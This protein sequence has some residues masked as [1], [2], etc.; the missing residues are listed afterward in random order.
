MPT[1]AGRGHVRDPWSLHVAAQSA[2]PGTPPPRGYTRQGL[3]IRPR[4]IACP[5]HA[6]AVLAAAAK[7]PRV[8]P[9][10]GDRR[11]PI[12]DA[13]YDQPADEQLRQRYAWQSRDH[14]ARTVV[15]IAFHVHRAVMARHRIC[16]DTLRRWAQAKSLY[17]QGGDPARVIVSPRTLA[18]LMLCS[19]ETVKRYNR[20]AREA[21]LEYVVEAGRML[22]WRERQAARACGSTQRGLATVAALCTP[23]EV[24]DR[25][26]EA[27]NRTVGRNTPPRGLVSPQSFSRSPAFTNTAATA[28]RTSLRSAQHPRDGGPPL[29][30]TPPTAH[31]PP[32][33]PETPH[34]TPK[35]TA[36]AVQVASTAPRPT[37]RRPRKRRN[38][39]GLGIAI[40][41]VELVPWLRGCPRG[42]IAPMLNKYARADYNWTA[43]RILRAMDAVN[44]RLGYNSP[45]TA[46]TKPWALLAWYLTQIDP[47]ADAP[48]A[49]RLVD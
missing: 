15:S 42:R 10:Q 43:T 7:D 36:K 37:Q 47:V 29:H 27:V 28:N 48:D 39:P 2:L 49:G 40:E 3:R 45:T 31:R 6:T 41:L 8:L 30:G 46:K 14:W 4:M 16:P 12:R 26:I 20:A 44:T 32:Q 5:A 1:I 25:A 24:V 22:T 13:H 17:A 33:P 9:R 21:G 18:E 34:R 11:A 38:D 19:V 35:Q 23:P